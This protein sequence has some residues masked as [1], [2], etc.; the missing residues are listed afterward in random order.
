VNGGGAWD[1]MPIFP[2][3]AADDPPPVGDPVLDALLA[4]A[5]LP[6]G[7]PRRLHSMAHALA[8]LST[9]PVPEQ[10][11][12]EARAMAAFRGTAG[13]Q[14][15]THHPRRRRRP[16]LTALLSAKLAAAAL[17]VGVGGAAA[18][19]YAGVLPAPVQ[20]LA[21]DI[22][23]APAQQPTRPAPTPAAAS[24][25]R[26][27]ASTPGQSGLCTAYA[28]ARAHGSAAQRAVAFRRLAAAAGG[29][30][31]VAAYCATVPHAAPPAAGHPTGQPSARP[32]QA[33]ATHRPG[34][35]TARPT[36]AQPT[37]AQPRHPQPS[38]PHPQPSHATG[39]PAGR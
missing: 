24:P 30:G 32:T 28:N 3:P 18:A 13:R 5:P 23:G 16:M 25:A 19:S 9:A 17:A 35:P 31:K 1:D 4:R 22:I 11:G 14:A 15:V 36:Q 39:Q 21:H 7:T 38:H 37:Q 26:P 8:E 27:A 2:R 20:K 6:P 33:H 12:A 10:P 29:V 34:R